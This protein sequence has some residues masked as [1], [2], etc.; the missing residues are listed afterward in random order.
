MKQLRD[1]SCDKCHL[2]CDL[3]LTAREMNMTDELK[4]VN[5]MHRK[6]ETISR[7][8]DEITHA[9]VLLEGNAKMYIDGINRKSIILNILIP[10]NYIGLMAVFGSA[11]YK[12]NIE[13]ITDCIT[14]HVDI[15]VVKKMY[16]G[17]QSFM[18]KLNTAIGESV[19]S[20]MSKLI[21]LNQKHIRG[22]V[23]ESL[24]YLSQLYDSRKYTLT[25]TRKELGELSA[26]SEENTVRALAEFR[27][28]GIIEIRGREFEIKNP[29][30]LRK[31]SSLG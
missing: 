25:L 12:Y 26:I 2:K 21:S 14:C 9:I 11:R 3:W 1:I 17:N 15:E 30:L 31:I 16:N 28:E 22:K 5:Y 6:H 4:P 27:K 13:A 19:S 18:L 29:D 8:G 23:A 10:S 7:Q 24:L 20:I